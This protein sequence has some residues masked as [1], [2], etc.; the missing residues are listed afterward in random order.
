MSLHAFHLAQINVGRFR[1]AAEDPSLGDFMAALDP[2]NALAERSPGFVW[3]LKD[4]T[5][6]ATN[7][8][9]Y[10]DPRMIINL[11]V[12]ESLETLRNFTYRSAHTGVLGRRNDWFEKLEGPHLALWWIPGGA[13]PTPAEGIAR[14]DHLA[15]HGPSENAFTFSRAFPAPA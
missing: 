3:R 10:D 2:I 5:G 14:I 4:E 11:T 9:A 1:T 7:I 13:V 6:H 15:R 8:H 12:W